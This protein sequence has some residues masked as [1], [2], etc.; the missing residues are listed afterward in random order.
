MAGNGAGFSWQK[1]PTTLTNGVR[2]WLAR[3]R[4][5][6]V[7]VATILGRDLADDARQGAPWTDRTGLARKS[8]FAV[9]IDDAAKQIVTIYL[10]HGP[11]EPRGKS[12]GLELARQQK[13]AAI[14]PAI[15][16][17]LPEIEQRLRGI[18]GR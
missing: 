9:A 2:A 12:I 8:L 1:P 14:W 15:V 3:V 4:A 6:V 17:N 16:R 18:F 11:N 10:S 7:A 5:A 13:H